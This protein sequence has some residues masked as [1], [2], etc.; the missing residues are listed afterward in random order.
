MTASIWPETACTQCFDAKTKCDKKFP[1]N[2]CSSKS[3]P[4]E[5][6]ETHRAYKGRRSKAPTRENGEESQD[7]SMIVEGEAPAS[8]PA[9]QVRPSTR[10]DGGS[11]PRSASYDS[12]WLSSEGNARLLYE[13]FPSPVTPNQSTA[14]SRIATD[15]A[16]REVPSGF[17]PG[18]STSVNRMAVPSLPT[19]T[20]SEFS[21]PWLV[22]QVPPDFME[23]WDTFFDDITV[24]GA[25]TPAD[26]RFAPPWN[27]DHA[28]NDDDIFP[29]PASYAGSGMGLSATSLSSHPRA[30]IDVRRDVV[31]NLRSDD[32]TTTVERN[33]M[34]ITVVDSLNSFKIWFELVDREQAM[35]SS[36]DVRASLN[37]LLSH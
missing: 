18:H 35:Q 20:G 3:L 1:C 33:G 13:T 29:I 4:C 37:T 28:P 26:P 12:S 34:K 23:T 19:P 27:V 8:S 5:M 32:A 25:P 30:D 2:R 9:S 14:V 10:C 24:P 16:K 17:A 21:P 22:E 31:A 11:P 15:G 7:S 6:K 36:N